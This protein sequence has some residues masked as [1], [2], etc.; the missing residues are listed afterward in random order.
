[1][2]E[3]KRIQNFTQVP[4][5]Y[6]V[7]FWASDRSIFDD[8]K[9]FLQ[10]MSE[11]FRFLFT[12]GSHSFIIAHFLYTGELDNVYLIA[13]EISDTWEDT[14]LNYRFRHAFDA[15]TFNCRTLISRCDPY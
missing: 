9:P 1:M 7:T 12:S 8:C 4:N 2:I 13:Q 14:M 5:I 6:K 15:I 3:L 11:H 10:K